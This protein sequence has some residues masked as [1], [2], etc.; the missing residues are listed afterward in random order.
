ME[1]IKQQE[2]TTKDVL[3]H[4]F[5][6]LF[7]YGA[8]L[9]FITFC[10]ALNQ[11]IESPYFNYIGFFLIYYILYVVLA[12]PI[13]LN[14][15]PESILESRTVAIVDYIKRQ[16]NKKETTEEWLKN[17]EP[18]ENEK[19]AMVI[20]FMKAFFGVYCINLL[21]NKY[22]PSIGYDI[23]FLKEMFSQAMQYTQSAG[24]YLGIAQY[25]DDTSDMWLTIILMLST[26]I[27][28]FSYTTELGFLKNKIKTADTTPL[29][30][31]SCIM[32]YYPIS[33]LTSKIIVTYPDSLVPVDNFV[34]R[35]CL[36]FLIVAANLV[37]L[38]AIARL[39]TKSGNLTNRG[40]VTGFPYNIVRHPNY[41]MEMFYII[42][43]SIPMYFMVDFSILEKSL[44]TIGIII[45]LYI[46]YLRSIT[47]ER[48]LI[49]DPEYKAYVEKVKYRF[50]PKVF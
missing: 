38:L 10:P 6:S 9:L 3:K 13:Y 18:K 43:T 42:L 28:A 31:I 32:C 1:E 21:C 24:I 35:I 36:S 48:H 7:I 29:G 22:L 5:S 26:I 27:F 25:I 12:L 19:Q 44:M 8:I 49:K 15:K 39:G 41:S 30:I 20:V 34:L 23:D 37:A 4:Y 33:I 2:V 47:E 50:I 40:I 46:Y 16:F 11:N 14:F 17:I 45:W